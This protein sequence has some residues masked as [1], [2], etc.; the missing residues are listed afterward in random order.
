MV[1]LDPWAGTV[2]GS[3][4][5]EEAVGHELDLPMDGSRLVGMTLRGPDDLNRLYG[6]ARV[7]LDRADGRVVEALVSRDVSTSVSLGN[8][9]H[10]LHAGMLFGGAG[11][12]ITAAVGLAL[13][14]LSVLGTWVWLKKTVFR[15]KPARSAAHGSATSG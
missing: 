4:L 11:R 9:M 3:F 10:S 2:R 7:W 12:W 14:A 6:D 1:S 8:M 13:A 5:L 15:R